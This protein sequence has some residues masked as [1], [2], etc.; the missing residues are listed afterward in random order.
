[1]NGKISKKKKKKKKDRQTT[2]YEDFEFTSHNS[3]NSV[4]TKKKLTLHLV[5][6]TFLLVY[7]E[8]TS[9]NYY[10]LGILILHLRSGNSDFFSCN[11]V[12]ISQLLL[13]LE[14]RSLNWAIITFLEFWVY[15]LPFL[16]FSKFWVYI[17]QFWLLT[18]NS[19]FTSHISDFF[20]EFRV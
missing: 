19:E 10:F 3:G 1:M 14:F 2:L 5:I 12:Y 15:I 11:S 17:S 13:L 16:L 20:S 9:S 8:F 18:R 4:F 7:S 6:L